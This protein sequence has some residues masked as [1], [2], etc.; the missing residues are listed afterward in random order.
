MPVRARPPAFLHQEGVVEHL[1]EIFRAGIADEADHA[2]RLVLRAAIAQRRRQQRAGGRAGER[3][4]PRATDR[5]RPRSCPDP[6]PNRPRAPSDRS[7]FGGTKS[8]PMPST[9]Q[10]PASVIFPVLISG[11]ST[12][13][14]GS[15]RI[16]SVVGDAR[17]MK[18]PTPVSVPPEPTP[19]TIGV[20]VVVHLPQD[21]RRGRLLVR[22]RIGRILEL[23]DVDRAGGFLRHR[24]RHVLIIVRMAL[25]DI[26]ARDDH[27]GAHR[28][29]M[30]DLLARH[31]VGNDQDGAIAF[32]RAD[33]GETKA[34]IARGRLNDGAAGFQPAV[35]FRGFDH[36]ARR[37]ILDRARRICAFEL[38]KQLAGAGIE[39]RDRDERRFADEVDDACHGGLLSASMACRSSTRSQLIHS[40]SALLTASGRSSV[41]RCPQS[42]MTTSRLSGMSAA[43][44]SDKPAA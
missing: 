36:R 26:R 42:G 29:R 24:L 14:T 2:L 28:A 32:L 25:A 13:P 34:G 16:I 6:T 15:A 3:Y 33:E 35:G 12:E 23:V 17:F 18:R 43:I 4:P 8:S 5:A 30:Q 37:A 31:L 21:F 7:Q 38:E 10:L 27:L 20:D 41:E 1:G 11:A 19:T 40:T 44:S 9:A 39:P 22:E